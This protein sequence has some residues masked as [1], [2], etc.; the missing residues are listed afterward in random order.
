MAKVQFPLAVVITG[1]DVGLEAAL[2]K[3]NQRLRATGQLASSVGRGLTYGVTLPLL[4]AGAAAV[5]TG[6][7]VESNILQVRAAANLTAQQAEALRLQARAYGEL[8][9]GARDASAGMVSYAKAGL[10]VA[11]I[12]ATM[13]PTILL[14]K[15]ANQ[16]FGAV[17][18]GLV[19][20]ISGYRKPFSE[21]ASVV[22]SLAFAADATTNDVGDLFE[23][24]KFG[25]PVAA[26]MNQTF[27]D[28][29]AILALMGQNGFKATLGGTALRD[30][31]GDL[32][33]VTPQAAAR[34]A[35]LGIKPE[36]W[37]TSTGELKSLVDVVALLE[38][39][40]ARAEDVMA[41]FGKTSG[42]ALIS[43]L[44]AGSSAVRRLSRE[45]ENSGGSAMK[46][47]QLVTSGAQ[48]AQDRLAAS[49][50]NLSDT[51]ATG[52]VLDAFTSGVRT[53]E[54]WVKA[55]DR[56][57]PRT[58]ENL[59][60]LGGVAAAVGP[61][62]LA[63]GSVTTSVLTAS[64]AWKT[65]AA[66][67]ALAG[68]TAAAN[69]PKV[70]AMGAA[71]N[72]G[73]LAGLARLMGPAAAAALLVGPG[74]PEQNRTA[75]TRSERL[76]ALLSDLAGEAGE[77]PNKG[78]GWNFGGGFEI[79]R[80]QELLGRGFGQS[81]EFRERHAAVLVEFKN[82]PQGTRIAT[83]GGSE[84]VNLNVGYAMASP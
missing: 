26:G 16:E 15:S 45:L 60:L 46:K 72:A 71:A 61:V 53:I 52:G 67:Q 7:A 17:A 20:V 41:I 5:R 82:V 76:Q 47:Y 2:G 25:G 9:V 55:F 70:A 69:A 62:L 64:A 77:D 28:T 6:T 8:G 23:A 27:E 34:L 50:Q 65:L 80:I 43:L 37:K 19:N 13:R 18:D 73:G 33:N 38:Q 44:G 3:A 22:D 78:R 63:I 31:M 30:M 56:L 40:G 79:R 32:A 59:I 39:H 4:A 24:L 36:M 57:S 1:Q 29:V 11:E 81:T 58:K 84:G 54:G 74:T 49:L 48:G 21:A 75:E 12:N 51:L 83:Q 66:A 14:A 68:T 42:P 10:S 35:Q